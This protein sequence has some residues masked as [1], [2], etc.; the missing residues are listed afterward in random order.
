LEA[1]PGLSIVIPAYN[2]KQ[3]LSLCLEALRS[4]RFRDFEIL[5]V[6][7]C[8]SDDPGEVIQSHGATYLR[9]PRQL[10]PAGARNLGSEHARGQ[11]LVFIDSDVAVSP[12]T[13]QI[14]AD[15]FEQDTE[16]AA[17]FGSYDRAPA[18]P[19]FFSQY[20]NLIHHYVH[21]NSNSRA[22]TFWA[23][24]GAI[25]TGIFRRFG[26]DA[27]KY[28]RPS[29]EDI[30]LGLRLRRA[31]HTILLDKRI[32]VTHLKHW[33]F[34]SMLESDIRDRAIPWSKLIL[35][36]GEMPVD[37]NLGFRSRL[38][39]ATTLLLVA[40][41]LFLPLSAR[42]G[43]L[44]L[45]LA[46]LGVVSS[47]VLLMVLNGGVYGFFRKQRGVAF[48]IAAMPIHWLYY[49]YSGA[50][51]VCCS[52]SHFLGKTFH[53][54]RGQTSVQ[55]NDGASA[56]PPG[57]GE[58][59]GSERGLLALE[60]HPESSQNQMQESGDVVIIGAGPAGLTAAYE[61]SKHGRYAVVLES[62]DVV[63]GIARTV[64]YK[65]YLFDIGGHRFF[66]KWDEVNRIWREILG[67][68]FLERQRSSRILY[69]NR[70]FLY[71]LKI[72]DVLRG[73]GFVESLRIVRSYVYALLF[74]FREEETLEHWV[75]NRFG[76]RLYRAFFKTY[77]EKVWGVP[78]S[79]IHADWAAQ[80]IKGL[81]FVSAIRSAV[82]Q[83]RGNRVKS[84]I[85]SFHYPERGPGQMWE[86]LAERLQHCGQ[87][88]LLRRRVV[89]LCHEKGQVTRVVT[90]SSSSEESFSGSSFISS[91]PIRSLVRA[92]HPP[93]PPEVQRAA[94]ALRYRD[95]LT[96]VLIVNRKDALA[97]N[98]IYIHEPSVKV[99]RIQNFKNWS[100]AMV[101]DQEKTSLGLEYF[102]FHNDEL[103]QSSDSDLI[104]LAT[105]EIVQLGLVRREE[106][107][108]GTVVRMPKA[109]P[110]YD[111]GW[112]RNVNCI[113]NYL[114]SSLPNLQL[115]G[116]NGMHKYNNQDHSMM[117]ALFA[118]R[119]IMGAEYDLWA[120][121]T[122]PEYQ[123]E[124]QEATRAYAELRRPA[125]AEPPRIDRNV[126]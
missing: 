15:D 102:V 120:V 38:S 112:N 104:E 31:G 98:W 35:E 32:Q 105:R 73:M 8:S 121:N 123:E 58:G 99:G 54:G 66:S 36:T 77:T 42:L 28:P 17:V 12:D 7:D 9:A 62:D 64:D 80:R 59:S 30:E 20:K 114:R 82:F 100:P 75:C 88:I 50:V 71:P 78:C 95:F 43:K 60:G 108:D 14:I 18:G 67:D 85:S 90:R 21:Q 84:L 44:P 68:K 1:L 126:A 27:G 97:D 29:I 16:L 55:G 33:S 37:L 51:W 3:Q 117:T 74:P 106:I 19:G 22:V 72:G 94:E 25:R 93:A 13:L 86:T 48:M 41:V 56:R 115:V 122:E 65:G 46:A 49:F 81:S 89:R 107:E 79:E 34:T 118:A 39:A 110:M 45:Q 113:R 61:L 70:F 125:Y 10:G 101:P 57:S 91:M 53:I 69:R 103:W 111:N 40:L 26:F 119:N 124:Q 23:G 96:V 116:R 4:S 52:A 87:S 109:Y 92:L 6:D 5:V 76:A 63:G 83:S 11:V 47:V 2:A 24:C